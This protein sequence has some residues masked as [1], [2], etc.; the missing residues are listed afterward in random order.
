MMTVT[1]P[2]YLQEA[3]E[4][5]AAERQVP[6]E[7]VVKEGL[8]WYLQMDEQLQDELAAWQEVRDEAREIAEGTES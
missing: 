5:R 3:L 4:K 1:I 7:Q 2:S 8:Q 6:V